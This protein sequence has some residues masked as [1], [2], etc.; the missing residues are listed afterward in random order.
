MKKW[1]VLATTMM[2]SVSMAFASYAAGWKSDETGWWYEN[3]DGSYVQNG[4]ETIDG[5][6]YYFGLDGY[7]FSNT[8]TPDGQKVGVDGALIKTV[9]SS[10]IT[11]TADSVTKE[12]IISDYIYESYSATYHVFEITNNSQSTLKVRINETAKDS[13]GN[14]IGAGSAEERDIPA[15]CT[16][17]IN[18]YLS[19][20]KGACSFDTSIQTAVD[21][22]YIPVAQN[23]SL[24]VTNLGDKVLVKAANNGSVP[25]EFPEA[26]VLFFYGDKVVAYAT[27]YFCD[28]DYELKP[29]ASMTEQIS[30][31]EDYTSV[32]VHITAR[33]SVWSD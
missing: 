27:K 18:N 17:F 16:V 8:T 12:L 21:E 19:D 5:K 6:D 4:W 1:K 14:I 22:Y 10:N 3:D 30:A 32:K 29:G 11:Y 26:T 20:V 24:E 9:S 13:S 7:M 25:A 33:R 23:I 31:Y 15:G 2:L 28:S